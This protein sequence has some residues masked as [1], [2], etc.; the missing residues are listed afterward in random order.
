[1]PLR[2]GPHHR[3]CGPSSFPQT[4]RSDEQVQ[5]EFVSDSKK[6]AAS[7]RQLTVEA[8]RATVVR[9]VL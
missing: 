7:V 4:L 2:I 5:H 6:L 1:M 8:D 3:S 9:I